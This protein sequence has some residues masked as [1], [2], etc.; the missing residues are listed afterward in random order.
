[1]FLFLFRLEIE[2][3]D[4]G[5]LEFQ[6]PGTERVPSIGIHHPAFLKSCFIYWASKVQ[7]R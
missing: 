6:G 7:T 3:L 4:P 1:M 5:T 2:I